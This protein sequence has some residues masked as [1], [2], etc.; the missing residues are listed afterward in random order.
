MDS[1]GPS[2]RIYIINS[3][4]PNRKKNIKP[5]GRI[6]SCVPKALFYVY[7]RAPVFEF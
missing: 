1:L 2:S 7:S 5:Y 3:M 4:G 6:E